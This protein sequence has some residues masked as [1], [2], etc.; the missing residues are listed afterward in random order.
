MKCHA[1]R[2]FEVHN[3]LPTLQQRK[4][5]EDVFGEFGME[6]ALKVQKKPIG[7]LGLQGDASVASR[8]AEKLVLFLAYLLRVTIFHPE[9]GVLAV[10]VH[11]QHR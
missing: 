11:V 3:D 8:Y 2:T 7:P 9:S 1:H 4:K 5:T 6:P 10:A